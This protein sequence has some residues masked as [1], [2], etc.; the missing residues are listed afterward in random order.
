M[1]TTRSGASV[2]SQ[3]EAPA[4]NKRRRTSGDPRAQPP[5][6]KP[7]VIKLDDDEDDVFDDHEPV[8]LPHTG[9]DDLTTI[10][11][12]EATEVPDEL[13]EVEVDNRIKL[14]AFQCVICMDD[15][16]SLTVTHCGTSL[17]GT[18]WSFWTLF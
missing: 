10:D 11:L 6:K 7:A 1:P 16:S 17:I 2:S 4:P 3:A 18:R 5:A 12:T 15:V 9:K 14:V 13:R 8:Q